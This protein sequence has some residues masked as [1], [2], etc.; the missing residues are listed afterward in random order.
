LQ[1]KAAGAD[2]NKGCAHVTMPDDLVKRVVETCR[3]WPG[4][5]AG[6]LEEVVRLIGGGRKTR[7]M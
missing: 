2:K 1:G 7:W 4:G 3:W 5:G 6:E